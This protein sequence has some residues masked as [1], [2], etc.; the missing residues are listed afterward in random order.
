M[1]QAFSDICVYT[2]C[3]VLHYIF[4]INTF[5]VLWK[6]LSKNINEKESSPGANKP[7]LQEFI[8]SAFHD[9]L[10]MGTVLVLLW[11]PLNHYVRRQFPKG[12]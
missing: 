1:L 10:S 9:N 8:F 11:V 6:S 5:Y 3:S 4:H 12:V 2:V 7:F